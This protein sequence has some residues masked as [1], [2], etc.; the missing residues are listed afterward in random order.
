MK[1][2][3]H[4]QDGD[5]LRCVETSKEDD[6]YVVFDRL[7]YPELSGATWEDMA[8]LT[9]R[10]RAYALTG[11]WDAVVLAWE[12][13]YEDATLYVH[14]MRRPTEEELAEIVEN[15]R[16]WAERGPWLSASV[17]LGAFRFASEEDPDGAMAGEE[18]EVAEG[19]SEA[20]GEA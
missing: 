14:G 18:T 13:D 1:S 19:G 9:H 7:E 11:E 5:I 16:R 17:G 4:R 12:G 20:G 6:G 2:V 10:M 8:K 3:Y 15:E